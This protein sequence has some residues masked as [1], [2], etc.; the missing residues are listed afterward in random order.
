[1]NYDDNKHC[2]ETEFSARYHYKMSPNGQN[3]VPC[4][5]KDSPT[6]IELRTSRDAWPSLRFELPRQVHE[7]GR[8]EGMLSEVFE[9][10]RRAKMAEIRKTLK[11]VIGL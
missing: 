2:T 6:V 1:M 11:D 10:G 9:Q 7:L 4:G 3:E 5:W 8:V